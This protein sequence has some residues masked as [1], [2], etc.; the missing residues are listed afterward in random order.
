M[1]PRSLDEAKRYNVWRIERDA[2]AALD[3]LATATVITAARTR[4]N[5]AI[6]AVNAATTNE[7][8]DGVTL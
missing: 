6:D 8:A 2:A 1:D 5:A 3:P 7:E 4:R